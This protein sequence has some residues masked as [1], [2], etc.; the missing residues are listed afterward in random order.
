MATS[1]LAR[2]NLT[3]VSLSN[4]RLSATAENSA[5]NLDNGVSRFKLY[6]QVI[7]YVYTHTES[8]ISRAVY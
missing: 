5:H 8:S 3:L 2:E 7:L 6:I 1:V 4:H